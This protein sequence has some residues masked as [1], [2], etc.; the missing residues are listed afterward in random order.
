MSEVLQHVVGRFA[1][2]FERVPYTVHRCRTCCNLSIVMLGLTSHVSFRLFVQGDI[3]AERVGVS[4]LREN[5]TI[6]NSL[7]INTGGKLLSY[8]DS[9]PVSLTC[10]RILV[11]TSMCTMQ[12]CQLQ[13]QV[14][15]Q[16][17]WRH[18]PPCLPR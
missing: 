16:L 4:S 17:C 8:P 5:P 14:S 12:A 18:C 15:I 1:N 2:H 11:L 9:T 6:E 3:R 13:V 10:C 7:P